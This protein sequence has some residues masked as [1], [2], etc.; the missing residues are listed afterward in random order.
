[1]GLLD[2]AGTNPIDHR[3]ARSGI[4]IAD[5]ATGPCV[6]MYIVGRGSNG[7]RGWQQEVGINLV[8]KKIEH[9]VIQ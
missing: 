9:H 7:E 2:R 6:Y 4:R 5:S 8:K 1:M 3:A